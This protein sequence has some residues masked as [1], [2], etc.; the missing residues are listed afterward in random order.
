M[1]LVFAMLPIAAFAADEGAGGKGGKQ[2]GKGGANHGSDLATK[3]EV[4][5]TYG[6]GGTLDASVDSGAKVKKGTEVKFTAKP[7]AGYQVKDWKLNG[8]VDQTGKDTY[9][10]K[11][12]AAASVVVTFEKIPVVDFA[13]A[14]NVVNGNGSLAAKVGEK[15]LTSGAKVLKGKDVQFTATPK[16]GYQVKEWKLNG[17]VVANNTS[18]SYKLANLEAAATVTVEFEK[19]I[20]DVILTE[21]V[22]VKMVWEGDNNAK[23]L[24]P[25]KVD[26]SL[27][28]KSEEGEKFLG[29]GTVTK[30]NKWEYIFSDL[31]SGLPGKY[32]LK[33]YV[34]GYE[35]VI[36]PNADGKTFTVTNKL[37]ENVVHKKPSYDPGFCLQDKRPPTAGNVIIVIPLVPKAGV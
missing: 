27:L 12:N 11:V 10:L 29:K 1:A 5:Y 16:D 21:T 20:P 9:I 22:K 17:A 30:N 33:V 8:K 4:V 36:K 24:R 6:N 28:R 31:D 14:F 23:N 26:V 37:K 13:V 25:K 15:A 19:I 32:D 35:T 34:P 2:D 3:Y 7:N 18:N